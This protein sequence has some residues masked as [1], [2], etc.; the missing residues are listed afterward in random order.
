MTLI[1][2]IDL[3]T[4]RLDLCAIPL[5]LE[6]PLRP[7][8]RQEAIP[9]LDGSAE[10]VRAAATAARELTAGLDLAAICVE[11]P[12]GFSWYT[13]LPVFGAVIAA[14]P[15]DSAVAWLT[16]SEWRRILGLPRDK[17]GSHM[18][19]IDVLPFDHRILDEHELDCL[20]VALA[21]R[22]ELWRQEAA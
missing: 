16:A 3:S 2:G 10:R 5:D 1:A 18:S 20:G 17:A 9:R 7:V 11:R 12:A 8:W 13:L 6:Q 14:T 15:K 21:W 22:A 19:L 4:K